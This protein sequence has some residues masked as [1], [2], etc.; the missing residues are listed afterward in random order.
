MLS[1]EFIVEENTYSSIRMPD[2]GMIIYL[3]S[4]VQERLEY[5]PSMNNELPFKKMSFVEI[6][7]MF[8]RA[9]SAAKK[10]IKRVPVGCNFWI[11]D[12][13]NNICFGLLRRFDLNDGTMSIKFGTIIT[14][15]IDG[16]RAKVVVQDIQNAE[17]DA[18]S[19]IPYGINIG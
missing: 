5:R 11:L 7:P 2:L 8:R 6:M 3:S 10:K 9:L 15:Y 17:N 14:P 4:H 12:N 13:T 1:K 18:K 19:K 16:T